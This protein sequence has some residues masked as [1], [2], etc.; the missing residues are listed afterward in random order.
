M[1][2]SNNKTIL[3]VED[4]VLIAMNEKA[5]LEKHGFTVIT[6]DSGEKAIEIMESTPG[7]DLVLMDIYLG[8][9]ML[10]TE[11]AEKILKKHKVPLV[12]ISSHDNPDQVEL[13]EG[14]TSYGFIVKNAGETGLVMSVR[15]AFRLFEAKI[16]DKKKAGSGP[17]P[18]DEPGPLREERTFGFVI[19]ELP[20]PICSLDPDG[21]YTYAN[22]AAALNLG[23]STGELVGKT[24]RDIFPADEA[25]YMYGVLRTCIETGRKC[26]VENSITSTAGTRHYL[27][28]LYPL[29]G[30]NG[31][32]SSII[33]SAKDITDLKNA[34][35]RLK[36]SEEKFLKAF[37]KSPVAMDITRLRDYRIIEV[38]DMFL[39]KSGFTREE[40]LGRTPPELFVWESFED[41]EEAKNILIQNG[42]IIGRE[43]RYRMK[44]GTILVGEYSGFIITIGGEK[45]VLVWVLDVTERRLA[46]D[47]VQALL[48][49]KELLLREV[50][51]RIKN[52][53][54]TIISLLSLQAGTVKSPEAID[55]LRDASGRVQSMSVLYNRLNQSAT[56]RDM[57]V[58]V[59]LLPLLDEIVSLFPGGV[60]ATVKKDIESF[61]L[62]VKV[63][64]PLGIIVNELVTN[65][66]KY[67][68]P[69]G[70]GG[71]I[72]VAASRQDRTVTLS[73]EDD[74]I[75]LPPGF[76]I[77]KQEGFGLDLVSLLI[78]QLHG[79]LR[80]EPAKGARFVIQFN[81]AE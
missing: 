57:P 36:F 8:S 47:R 41:R 3:L 75:G 25:E 31:N 80:V 28:T 62:D 24:I 11:A 67:A 13:T 27:T 79:T 61:I 74:G 78:G 5:V 46:Q 48:S 20:D 1:S 60:S 58:D 69:G 68:F 76:D 81:V 71:T 34:Q 43:Y 45:H 6:A 39:E 32:V 17:A 55:A 29:P 70:G 14:I 18:G 30:D 9:G 56:M 64:T 73:V 38:N 33:V 16:Q 65:A 51:H 52:N 4:E 21:R 54:N 72:R 15:M 40:V 37:M 10:G 50:H 19:E 63:L 66:M 23:L 22:R 35:E 59:Y 2:Y 53:M 77:A 12:F 7:I 26:D 49:E 44:D 42:E